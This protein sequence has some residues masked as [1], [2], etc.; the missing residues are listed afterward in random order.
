MNSIRIFRHI[1][2][3]G[4]AFLQTLLQEKQIPFELV[5]IDEFDA[6]DPQLDNIGGLIFMG[7]SMSVNDP[8]DWI[9]AELELIRKAV[10]QNIPVLGVCLGCQ[11]LVRAL[12]ARVYPGPCMEI[13]WYPVN[14][15][16]DQQLTAGLPTQMTA[17]HWHGETFDLPG[18][19]QL[20][21]SSARYQNQGFAIG[22]HLGLQFH[23]EME[24]DQVREWLQRNP[25]DL[26]RRCEHAHDAEA[27]MQTLDTRIA[28]LQSVA[29][30]LFDNW[31]LNCQLER[32]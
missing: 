7:G 18:E 9:T 23:V 3:E 14:C 24:A 31:L 16:A 15:V 8:L 11:L 30:I 12:G 13:G 10:A 29:R 22:P 1:D 32:V 28:E 4:P 21:F 20:L 19:A 2:C 5:R 6:I 26:E 17:F 25:A 27:I